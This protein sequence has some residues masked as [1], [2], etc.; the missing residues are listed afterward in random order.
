MDIP[1]IIVQSGAAGAV[2]YI[3]CVFLKELRA[4][5]ASRDEE[6]KRF[7]GVLEADRL[8]FSEAIVCLVR[9]A[10]QMVDRCQSS[11]PT[12]ERVTGKDVAHAG[13]TRH[14]KGK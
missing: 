7:L 2:I 9:L 14:A 3:T 8:A 5:G 4:M 10:Q 12:S 1:S 11:V 6:R 13:N